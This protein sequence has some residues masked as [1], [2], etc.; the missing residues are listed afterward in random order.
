MKKSPVPTII[1]EE[2]WILVVKFYHPKSDD[3]LNYTA[4]IRIKDSGK[5]PVEISPS[6]LVLFLPGKTAISL[7][8]IGTFS[9]VFV[10]SDCSTPPLQLSLHRIGLNCKQ[11]SPWL[12]R[13]GCF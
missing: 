12:L 11:R 8:L 2:N 1:Y 4:I 6:L 3:Y 5:N 9:P 13:G 7:V 10:A